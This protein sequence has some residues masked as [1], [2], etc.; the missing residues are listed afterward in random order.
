MTLQLKIV[1]GQLVDGTGRPP[2]RADIGI[3]DGKIVQLGDLSDVAAPSLDASGTIVTPGFTD[4]HT[5]YDGQASWDADMIPSILHGVTTCVLG[6]CGVGFAPVR[7]QDRQSLIALMEGVEDIPGTALSEGITWNW[8]SFPQYLDALDFPRTLDIALQVTHDP[9]RVYVMGER[10]L[11]GEVATEAEI[12]AM[13]SLL[14][15]A[16][17]AGAVGFSTGRTDNHR[18]ADGRATPAAEASIRELEGIARAF[19][20]LSHGVLQAVSDFDMAQGPG[21]FDG[22]FDVLERMAA[23]AAGHPLSI[24]LMQRDQA[25]GQWQRILSRAEQAH[26]K[27]IPLRVQVASRAIGVMLGLEATFHP[28]VGYPSYREI[29]HLPLAERVERMRQPAFRAQLLSEKSGRL[30]GDGS[31]IPPLADLLLSNLPMLSR[32]IFRLGEQPHYEPAPE[33]SLFAEATRRGISPLE[34]MYDALLE[35]DGHELLYFPLYNYGAG[36][37]SAVQH[38]LA[39]PLALPGLGDAGAHVGTICDASMSTFLLTWWV[40]ERPEGRM[41]LERAVRMLAHD[42]ARYMGFHDRGTL[43]VGQRADINLIE[44]ENLRLKRPRL[45]HDLPAGGKRLIQEVDGF[46][47]TLVNGEVVV[48]QGKLTGARPGRVVRLGQSSS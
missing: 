42:T 37:L 45:L 5:H 13:Q 10:A 29:S 38:M 18:A 7:P 39:H 32:R 24:S 25:P 17:K 6:S 8:E 3:A 26:E 16:L 20:G 47:A 9:L 4:L 22:E 34:A 48:Q 23:A 35:D 36:N 14:R 12:E 2:Y 27:G 21:P 46:R 44:L 11:A 31:P 15:Q 41:P 1:G 43:E 40:R 30:S 19:E 33:T 28:F